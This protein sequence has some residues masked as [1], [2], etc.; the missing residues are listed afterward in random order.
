MAF[1][2]PFLIGVVIT[3]VSLLI[4]SK[5]P[6]GV[7]IDSPQKALLGGLVL[8]ILNGIAQAV[9]G[10]LTILP[11]L[12]TLGL[13]SLIVNMI[14]FGLTAWLIEGFRL[15]MG[16]WSALLG[17]V[18]LAIINSILFKILSLVPGLG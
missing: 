7:E 13:F 17:A 2:I 14:F 8:G 1:L 12:L 16:I 5:L 6:F 11:K 3:A 18:S 15:R 4:I 10:I 9:P